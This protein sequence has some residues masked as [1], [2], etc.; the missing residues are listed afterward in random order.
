MPLKH[1]TENHS[2]STSTSPGGEK[3][4]ISHPPVKWPLL[5]VGGVILVIVIVVLLKVCGIM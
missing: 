2:N 4:A 3:K 5:A 1:A